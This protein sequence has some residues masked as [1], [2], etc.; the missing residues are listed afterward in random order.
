MKTR[1]FFTES[2]IKTR[3]G[4]QWRLSAGSSTVHRLLQGEQQPDGDV[5][6][7]AVA[8]AGTGGE[9]RQI[10]AVHPAGI[11]M[12]QWHIMQGVEVAGDPAALLVA[13]SLAQAQPAGDPQHHQRVADGTAR[14]LLA[15][16][17]VREPA[18]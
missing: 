9:Q 8:V 11:S 15:F 17:L 6:D 16:R 10:F 3:G 12:S 1:A 13:Q 7:T 14:G 5:A 4:L 18:L 2:S